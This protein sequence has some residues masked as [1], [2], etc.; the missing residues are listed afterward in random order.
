MDDVEDERRPRRVHRAR[1]AARDRGS[2]CG[3]SRVSGQRDAHPQRV[4]LHAVGESGGPRRTPRGTRGSSPRGP[5]GRPREPFIAPA[6]RR[7]R[8]VLVEH[9]GHGD[10]DREPAAR[11]GTRACGAATVATTVTRNTETPTI[12]GSHR[13]RQG[14][15]DPQDHQG[16]HADHGEGDRHGVHVRVEV[17]HREP[18]PGRR[19]PA[20]RPRRR[21]RP[22]SSVPGEGFIGAEPI[23]RARRSATSNAYGKLRRHERRARLPARAQRTP[24]RRRVHRVLEHGPAVLRGLA[25]VVR[26]AAV[27]HRRR[28][29]RAR[30]APTSRSSA[31]P[32]TRACRRGPGAGSA[33]GRSAWRRPRGAATTR[34]RSSWRRR[35]TRT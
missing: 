6:R 16:G 3:G 14:R 32:S 22:R 29:A 2:P 8:G 31:R 25:R 1:G 19:R 10:R 12:S 7:R 17:A 15:R 21:G 11:R 28:C 18:E 30:P 20:G 27:G 13:C 5:S 9:V 26:E 23:P 4:T 34:G 35:R 24:R 33:R